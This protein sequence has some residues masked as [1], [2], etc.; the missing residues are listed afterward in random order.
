MVGGIG[1][2]RYLIVQNLSKYL[3]KPIFPAKLLDGSTDFPN[4]LHKYQE[5]CIYGTLAD[6]YYRYLLP[7]VWC[8]VLKEGLFV[9][10]CLQP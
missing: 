1:L 2:N 9:I 6:V 5:V 3:A 7:G 8:L 10:S 4:S